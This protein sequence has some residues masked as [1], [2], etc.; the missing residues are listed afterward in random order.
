[1]RSLTDEV[2]GGI[3]EE[4]VDE[5]LIFPS[6]FSIRTRIALG[7]ELLNPWSRTTL[8]LSPLRR[9]ARPRSRNSVV[10]II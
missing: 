5:P 2:S 10:A 9:A 6:V 1:M 7:A 3:I 8:P 4:M